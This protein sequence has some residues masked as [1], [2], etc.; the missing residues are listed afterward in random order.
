MS[1]VKKCLAGKPTRVISVHPSDRVVVALTL[2]RDHRVRSVLVLEEQKLVGIITQGDCAIKVLLQ[3]R[4]AESVSVREVMTAA[5]LTV[6]LDDTLERCM[7][8]MASRNIR[9][10]PVTQAD[11]VVGV[12][13]IG[14]IVKDIIEQ[15]GSQIKY[16][17]T[18]IKGHGAG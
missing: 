7:N 6:T 12:V 18:Y 3:G 1:T 5:P 10:L 9:H 13:S 2:M 14:D 4:S 16:L 15:Q 17:E 8:V 11:K